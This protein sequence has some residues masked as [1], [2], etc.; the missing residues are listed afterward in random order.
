MR[1]NTIRT[2]RNKTGK[3]IGYKETGRVVSKGGKAKKE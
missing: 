1:R 3:I 2:D